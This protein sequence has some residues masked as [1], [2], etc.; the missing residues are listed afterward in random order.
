[1]APTQAHQPDGDRVAIDRNRLV[2]QPAANVLGKV[3]RPGVTILALMCQGLHANG[4]ERR[5]SR[6]LELVG[7]GQ[8]PRPNLAEHFANAFRRKPEADR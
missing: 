4:L 8:I 7:R 3:F 5:W 2:H 1:M 6:R